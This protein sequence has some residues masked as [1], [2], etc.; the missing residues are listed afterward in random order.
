VKKS[1]CDVW[2]GNM[3]E[4]VYMDEGAMAETRNREGLSCGSLG[5]VIRTE[6]S[7]SGCRYGDEEGS[8]SPR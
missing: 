7:D 1:D 8:S 4:K 6:V 2:S 5:S 3:W